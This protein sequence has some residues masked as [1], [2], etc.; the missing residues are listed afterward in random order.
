VQVKNEPRKGKTPFYP[1][2]KAN[3]KHV[4]RIIGDCSQTFAALAWAGYQQHGRGMLHVDTA[5]RTRFLTRERIEALH[6]TKT[7]AMIDVYNPEAQVIVCLCFAHPVPDAIVT[8][9]T[10]TVPPPQ[11]HADP[12]RLH[13]S[14]ETRH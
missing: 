12:M 2:N 13:F 9:Y 3:A 10:P 6:D 4:S 8:M 14:D 11:A 1:I 7:L 5:Q